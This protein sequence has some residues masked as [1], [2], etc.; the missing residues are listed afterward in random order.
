MAHNSGQ[1]S[2]DLTSVISSIVLSGLT[3]GNFKDDYLRQ[4]LMAK[5]ADPDPSK[6]KDRVD[7]AIGKWLG[8]ETR[9]RKTNIRLVDSSDSFIGGRSVDYILRRAARTIRRLLGSEVP[10]DVLRG[11][12]SG[13]AST[14]TRRSPGAVARKFAGRLDVTQEAW[15]VVW[16]FLY[17]E[18]ELWQRLNPK[19][20]KPR[21]VRGNVMFTVPKNDRIERV[22]CKEPDLNLFMQKA[23]GDFIRRRLRLVGINLNDQSI[24]RRL[25]R[26]G[27]VDGKL[28]TLDLSSASDSVTT[29]L[30][31]RLL[32]VDWFVFL[33]ALRCRETRMPDGSWHENEMFSSMGNGFTFELESL[34]FY[35][36]TKAVDDLNGKP[37]RVSV[38]GDDII[39]PT[40]SAGWLT[41]VLNFC[42]FQVN[43]EKSFVRGKFRE[44]CGGHY[45]SGVDVTPFYIR[46]PITEVSDLVRILNQLRNWCR[47][48]DSSSWCDG[49]W[50]GVWRAI[51]SLIPDKRL[52][53]GYNLS[54]VDVVASLTGPGYRLMKIVD[55]RRP[56][57][58]EAGLYLEWQHSAEVRTMSTE[59]ESS[60]QIVL[61]KYRVV[62]PRKHYYANFGLTPPAFPQEVSS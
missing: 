10:R 57:E 62:K 29:Q 20:L 13:G 55:H 32:P 25:A 22:A 45:L 39:V 56:V 41:H 7:A 18:T 4:S 24:N 33:E 44:S 52:F 23:A 61:D 51:A 54:A 34:I 37:G 9:N 5:F 21:F 19:L 16:P 43:K 6:L 3:P 14:S 31:C 17:R 35:S 46:R 58:T 11:G 40:R 59:A 30:V 47:I 15:D 12:F 60:V 38:Y 50:Y 42:G 48:T 27:S 36:L 8:T 49:D 2:R 26:E 1:L 28:A 53:G